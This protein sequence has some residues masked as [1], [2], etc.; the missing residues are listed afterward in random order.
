MAAPLEFATREKAARVPSADGEDGRIRFRAGFEGKMEQFR[1]VE[2]PS[3]L[4]AMSFASMIDLLEG[5]VTKEEEAE[6]LAAI[7]D[8]LRAVMDPS[9]W[10]RFKRLGVRC[11][12]ELDDLTPIVLGLIGAIYG[13]PTVPLSG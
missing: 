6:A 9:E 2:H 11:G 3:V 8:F 7:Y 4:P 5:D 12:W 13:R 1:L 10:R